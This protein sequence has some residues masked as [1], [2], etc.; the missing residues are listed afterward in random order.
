M[1]KEFL[2]EIKRVEERLIDI[3]GGLKK[4]IRKNGS[5]GFYSVEVSV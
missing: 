5:M 2:N 3:Q 1:N 4:K